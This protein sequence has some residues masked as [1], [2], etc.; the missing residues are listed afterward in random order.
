[1]AEIT[2]AAQAGRPT[3]SGACNRLR[4][5]G[6]IPAVVYGHG[7][8]PLPISIEGKELRT[9]LTTAS[10][11][12]A[13]LSLDV[14]GDPHL[15]LAREI[16]RH[17]VRHNVTHVDFQIVRRDEVVSAEVPIN[18]VGESIQV[19]QNQGVVEQPLISLTVQATP[20]RIPPSIEVDISSLTIGDT[21]RVADLPLPEG[22]TTDV[23]GEEAVV[24]AQGSAVAAQVAADQELTPAAPEEAAAS[25]ADEAPEA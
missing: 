22:V 24:I 23:D 13:L 11:L 6:R 16:Q 17:P 3:G 1:M 10:G 5:A 8:E 21:I 9:A 12:N 2:L 15:A 4:A 18:L 20:G 19:S 25:P 7:M 14:D